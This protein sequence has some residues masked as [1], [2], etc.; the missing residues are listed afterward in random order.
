MEPTPSEVAS[1]AGASDEDKLLFS[2][3][4]NA[5]RVDMTRV[6]QISIHSLN[7]HPRIE[8]LPGSEDFHVP[9]IF[10][11]S[12]SPVRAEPPPES[13]APPPA[14]PESFAPP[15]APPESFAPPPA[16]PESFAP[17]PAPPEACAPAEPPPTVEP[18]L[19]REEDELTKRTLLLDLQHLV[20][21]H[22]VTLTKHW[23]MDDRIEDLM[24]E[25]RRHTLAIDER[26]NVNMM[27]DGMRL[28]ITGIEMLNS[29]LGL[30]D[31]DG[32]STEVCRDLN[33]HDANLARIYRKYW[34]RNTTSS[35]EM[36][37]AM[38]LVGSMGMHH[39]RRTMSRNIINRTAYPRR[40]R[41]PDDSSDEEPP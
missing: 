21:Q 14:P 1:W 17:P 3:L 24:L 2:M 15:P 10:D 4:G 18:S 29:R 38:S 13:F 31:L 28:M 5:E 7:S 30:L 40:R 6:P 36:S 11:E 20:T 22:G 26:S 12:K 32:W 9:G 25:M 39:I 33:K 27:R 35:P 8:E 37:I 34:R 41:V 19:Q 23:T 16:P